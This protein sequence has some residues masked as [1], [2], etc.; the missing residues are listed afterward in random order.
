MDSGYLKVV[1]EEEVSKIMAF[2]TPDGKQRREVIPM[3]DLNAAPT[4]V[5]I[6]M[7]LEM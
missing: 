1:I 5:A 3:G 4:F 6:T 2:F 7:K